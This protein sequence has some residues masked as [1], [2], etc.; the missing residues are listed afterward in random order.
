[1]ILIVGYDQDEFITHDPGTSFGEYYHY[2]Q[3]KVYE[4]IHDLMSP[5]S[6][7]SSGPKTMLIF[8]QE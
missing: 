1:M 7:T 4:A 2:D 6:Q 8:G 3:N 5:E